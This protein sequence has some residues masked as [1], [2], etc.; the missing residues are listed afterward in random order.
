[1]AEPARADAV[2]VGGRVL[3]FVR[4]LT[5]SEIEQ[6]PAPPPVQQ[7]WPE[8]HVLF[9]DEDEREIRYQMPWPYLGLPHDE[10]T[11][12]RGVTWTIDG[13]LFNPARRDPQTGNW[14]FRQCPR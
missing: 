2:S 14:I 7:H 9:M 3:A 10:R 6:Y 4:R 11:K 13:Q 12:A 5:R 1:M 8:A